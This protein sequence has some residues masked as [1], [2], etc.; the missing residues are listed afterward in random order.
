MLW[1]YGRP[2]FNAF[3]SVIP[4]HDDWHDNTM[5]ELSR[6]RGDTEFLVNFNV[7][8]EASLEWHPSRMIPDLFE[9]ST[10]GSPQHAADRRQQFIA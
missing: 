3:P 4:D 6:P 8:Q 9:R 2:V 1:G 7:V 10:L 5:K